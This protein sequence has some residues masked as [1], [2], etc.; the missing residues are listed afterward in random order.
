M[1]NIKVEKSKNS[2]IIIS[3]EEIINDIN[4]YFKD[5]VINKQNYSLR[6]RKKCSLFELSIKYKSLSDYILLIDDI[7]IFLSEYIAYQFE[8]HYVINLIMKNCKEFSI[9]DK[10]IL[11]KKIIDNIQQ[12][13]KGDLLLEKL[14]NIKREFLQYFDE[15]NIL[16]FEGFVNFRLK[17]IIRSLKE[18]CLEAINEFVSKKEYDEFIELLK[19][20]ISTRD[21]K[22]KIIHVIVSKD[23]NYRMED[24]FGKNITYECSL[25]FLE[26]A[27][28]FEMPED[29]LLMSMLISVAP[30]KIIVH[31]EEYFTNK[32]ILEMIR[33]V[34]NGKLIL[35]NSMN[36]TYGK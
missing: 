14:H 4:K 33:E 11:F 31:N 19:Y 17:D 1:A 7:S 16:N 5:N 8:S 2:I 26:V 23:G 36:E 13:F 35:C 29:N 24:E 18:Y 30:K 32:T 3:R 10:N 6:K 34:F 15:N 20:F 22:Y 25:G 12:K 21:S 9:D 28:D 27:T